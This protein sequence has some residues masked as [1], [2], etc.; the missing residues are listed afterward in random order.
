M[1]EVIETNLLNVCDH[2]KIYFPTILEKIINSCWILPCT[3]L[4][5]VYK[6]ANDVG[7]RSYK[8]ERR[9]R[10]KRA[11]EDGCQAGDDLKIWDTNP[12]TSKPAGLQH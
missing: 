1:F 10:E 12:F 6:S 7:V 11:R 2:F 5:S 4:D 8:R 9:K 3:Y